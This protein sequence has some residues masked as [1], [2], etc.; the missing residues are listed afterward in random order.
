MV[1][2]L[3]PNVI[4]AVIVV[5]TVLPSL[6]CGAEGPI[7]KA[8]G[9]T[10]VE[11]NLEITPIKFATRPDSPV[12]KTIKAEEGRL[13]VPENRSNPTGRKVKIHFV[14]F[15]ANGQT[16]GYPTVYL[17][18]GP[19]GSGTY[20]SAGDRFPLF[21]RVREVGDVIALDQ[22]GVYLS[23]PYMVCPGSW[24]YPHDK[25]SDPDI[26]AAAIAPFINQC[27]AEWGDKADLSAYNTRESAADLDDLRQA[28]GAE[29]LNLW[30]ISYGTHLGLAYIRQ[31]PDRVN[32]A[33]LA[34]IEGPDHTYKLPGNVDRV[35]MRVAE[36]VAAD[37]AAH[38]ALPDF[39][40]SLKEFLAR[41]EKEPVE[42]EVQDPETKEEH[43]VVLGRLDFQKGLFGVLGERE[44]IE[45]LLLR[46]VPVLQGDYSGVAQAVYGSRRNNRELVMSLAMDCAS[47]ATAVRRETIRR[48]AE[49]ALL[50]NAP[51]YS[52]TAKCAAWPANDLGDTF[53]SPVRSDVPVLFIS[54]TLDGKTPPSNAAEVM[55][56]FPNGRHLIIEG[57]SHDDDLFL[58]SPRIADTM[59][60][61][62]KGGE[63]DLNPIV[64]PPIRFQVP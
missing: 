27:V 36:A 6:A 48:Q 37:P 47:G 56:G 28:L 26:L 45:E 61:F 15:A 41:V 44:D 1:I 62:L 63:P 51:N 5:M 40:G 38:A 39:I 60:E 23:E 19:G 22:R 58:S 7:K 10:R 20:S 31:F 30:G 55:E 24:D 49:T 9:P 8:I 43:T 21:Q 25:P 50:G 35:L 12:K 2:K 52:L 3:R 57:G 54:G 53:R 34:G 18:G 59:I 13:T 14:R 4:A 46:A 29:K 42:V 33:V 64:L 11:G 32:R 17:A 16:P